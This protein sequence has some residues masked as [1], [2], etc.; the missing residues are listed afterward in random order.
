MRGFV[1]IYGYHVPTSIHEGDL[2]V[3]KYGDTEENYLPE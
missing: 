3:R 2:A 1:V